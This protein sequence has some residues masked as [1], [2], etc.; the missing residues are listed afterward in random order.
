[1]RPFSQAPSDASPSL[2]K[3]VGSGVD[4]RT[5][6]SF[7]VAPKLLHDMLPPGWELDSPAP[8]PLGDANLRV[9]FVDQLQASV[10]GASAQEPIRYVLFSIPM[11]KADPATKATLL[12]TGLS[13]G[14]KGPYE[15]NAKATALVE[16][17]SVSSIGGTRTESATWK[18]RSDDGISASLDIEYL[19][20]AVQRE[21][22]EARTYSAAKSGFHRIYRYDQCID[23]ISGPQR[24]AR[25]KEIDFR[26]AGGVLSSLF[27]GNEQ[28]ISVAS[29]LWFARQVFL[30]VA[31]NT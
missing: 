15:V 8:G 25:L 3:L 28:L 24:S 21:Q 29:V 5:I 9:T 17:K 27:D 23:V 16:R 4:V 13:T 7:Y 11:R 30:P 19:P 1:M 26:A 20:G 22:A 2:E 10:P 14:G 6:L 31:S 18:F 12:F